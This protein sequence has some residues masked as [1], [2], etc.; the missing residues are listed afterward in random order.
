MAI[1]Y[2]GRHL[3]NG[4]GWEYTKAFHADIVPTWNWNR[5]KVYC[6]QTDRT[7]GKNGIQ[8][9]T[10]SMSLP[11]RW[12]LELFPSVFSV[13]KDHMFFLP[14]ETLYTVILRGRS[15]CQQNQLHRFEVAWKSQKSSIEACIFKSKVGRGGS[16][17][18]SQTKNATNW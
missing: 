18:Q 12:S 15:I 17:L 2:L 6:V 10:S 9:N 11:L 4:D 1:L 8:V 7:L 14:A 3:V 16:E 13:N 5:Y